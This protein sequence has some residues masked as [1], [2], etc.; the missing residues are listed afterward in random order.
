MAQIPSNTCP[1]AV[2]TVR[3]APGLVVNGICGEPVDPQHCATAVDC[4]V[5]GALTVTT[6]LGAIVANGQHLGGSHTWNIALSK[7][8]EYFWQ[9]FTIA[10][11]LQTYCVKYIHFYCKWCALP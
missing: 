4:T 6:N 11:P 2:L 5:M 10:D 8:G 7:C 3:W 9:Q 1:P